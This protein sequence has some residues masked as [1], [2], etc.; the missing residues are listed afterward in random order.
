[1]FGPTLFKQC[2]YIGYKHRLISA[3]V[4]FSGAVK[5]SGVVVVGS[6]TIFDFSFFS[7][8]P[9]E[10]STKTFGSAGERIRNGRQIAI[11]R[12]QNSGNGNEP[13]RGLP[14]DRK[15]QLGG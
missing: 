4:I 11:P 5:L 3:D 7:S 9:D 12:R 2:S 6:W 1:L 10:K 13:E 14:L 8:F 15:R